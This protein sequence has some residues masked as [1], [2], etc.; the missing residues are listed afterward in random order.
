MSDKT[1]FTRQELD[2]ARTKGQIIGWVQG[3]AAV[4]LG[5]LLIGFAGWIPLLL[6]GAVALYFVYRVIFGKS[7]STPAS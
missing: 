2:N 5:T 1:I 3:G 4:L 6:V 7:S